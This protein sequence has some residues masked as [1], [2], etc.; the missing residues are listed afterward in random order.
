M[1]TSSNGR[2]PTLCPNDRH[3]TI[4]F[5]GSISKSQLPGRTPISPH[6]G[7]N[8]ILDTMVGSQLQLS[9]SM[10]DDPTVS[11]MAQSLL[12]TAWSDSNFSTPWSEL[13][14]STSWWDPNFYCLLLRQTTQL[15]ANI[16]Q[17]QHATDSFSKSS[18]SQDHRFRA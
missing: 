2:N 3:S 18:N 10:A 11:Y 12:P 6:H 17:S 5:H 1:L 4:V 13:N 16:V 15:S 14:F 7:R 9:T 8:S